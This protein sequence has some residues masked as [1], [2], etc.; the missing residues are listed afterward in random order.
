MARMRIAGGVL[1][2]TVL[3]AGSLAAQKGP[4]Q[5]RQRCWGT[6][7]NAPILIE[8]YSDFQ[9][10]ACRQLYL[11]TIRPVMADYAVP[12]KA[13]V[14]Y[15]EFPLRN[16]EHSREASR[17]AHAA[18]RLG[19][20]KWVQVTDVLFYFQSQWAEDGGIEGVVA[21]ALSEKEMNQVRKWLGDDKLEAAIDRDLAQGRQ[22]R[23]QR[24]PTLFITANGK[25]EQVTGAVQYT[26]LRRYLDRLLAR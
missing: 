24:T 14:V 9:C 3:A 26:I 7:P 10:P 22:R 16:H 4:A 23:V 21:K 6:N 8:V 5:A 18:A 20:E 19:P 17:Y 2:L 1:L 13:C 15:Y 12:G 11:E 25:T